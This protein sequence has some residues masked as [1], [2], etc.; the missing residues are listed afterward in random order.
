MDAWIVSTKNTV[1]NNQPHH[2][3][4]VEQKQLQIEVV[5]L[6]LSLESSMMIS[7]V[8]R[9]EILVYLLLLLSLENMQKA[10][11]SI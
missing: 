9:L 7:N 1:S 2:L 11:Q 10:R 8:V 5:F 4:K 6:L 3:H